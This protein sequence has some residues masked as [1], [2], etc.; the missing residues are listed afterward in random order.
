MIYVKGKK[1]ICFSIAFNWRPIPTMREPSFMIDSFTVGYGGVLSITDI[2]QEHE[3]AP[4]FR[5]IFE[6]GEV[7][8]I[9]NPNQ[10]FYKP[11]EEVNV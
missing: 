3:I 9:Y 1:M 2:T 6:N 4:V 10:T 11:M 8:D 5:V 7:T